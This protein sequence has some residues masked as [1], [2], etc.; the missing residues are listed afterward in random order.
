MQ[1]PIF[2]HHDYRSAL[3]A[4][5]TTMPKRGHGQLAK[6]ASHLGVHP[7][8]ITQI[9]NGSKNLSLDQAFLLCEYLGLSEVETEYLLQLVELDRAAHYRLKARFQ[10][11]LEK[12]REEHERPQAR[13][14]KHK[15]LNQEDQALFYSNWYFSAIRLLVGI[16]GG[17]SV[18]RIAA[19]LGLERRTVHSVLEFLLRTG[20]LVEKKGCY[21]LGPQRTYLP[22]SSGLVSR[23]HANW[24]LKAIQ[25]FDRLGS[26]ELA[27]TGPISISRADFANAKKILLRALEE[28]SVLV[29]K[30]K[31]EAVG[32]LNLDLFWVT[33]K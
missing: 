28:I 21:L 20:L 2:D 7:T 10:A 9:L 6:I 23:H 18:D 22:A 13:M 4:Y 25:N 14:T 17:H 11:K 30:S 19:E 27:F 33:G 24:R 1:S 29:E 12:L 15:V 8:F 5:L 3:R 16:E 26:Q 31:E 32:C